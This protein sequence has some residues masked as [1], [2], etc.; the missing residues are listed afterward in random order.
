MPLYNLAVRGNHKCTIIQLAV[1]PIRRPD[2][3]IDIVRIALGSDLVQGVIDINLVYIRQDSTFLIGQRAFGK[4][5]HPGTGGGLALNVRTCLSGVGSD[6]ARHPH[7]NQCNGQTLIR[8]SS[9]S[10]RYHPAIAD[11]RSPSEIIG[12]LDLQNPQALFPKLAQQRLI[13]P[14]RYPCI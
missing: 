1:F 12:I 13:G 14:S 8:R 3:R 5:H 7:L 11:L 4:H 6:I 10:L 2:N 9:Q